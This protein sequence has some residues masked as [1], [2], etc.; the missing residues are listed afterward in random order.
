MCRWLRSP[1]LGVGGP[2]R[3]FAKVHSEAE[4]REAV[5]F[6]KSRNLPLFVL[7]GGSNLLVSDSGFNGLVLK[8]A[9]RGIQQSNAD[10]D[11]V[12]FQRSRWRRLGRPGRAR[13]RRRLCRDRVPQRDSRLG[14]WNSGTER[15]RLRAGSIGD[16][17]RSR[18]PRS[19]IAGTEDV[20]QRRLRLRL[21]QQPVQ[22]YGSGALH[23]S[24]RVVR[25][26]S[27]RQSHDSLH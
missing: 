20:Q 5:E 22:Y 10:G 2:A 1:R 12:I 14:W 8:I 7:G 19:A 11:T 17:P 26:S 4:V 3:Y 6:A 9:L 16:D 13:R 27:R 18:R 25:P 23:H 21:S 24:G 15:W